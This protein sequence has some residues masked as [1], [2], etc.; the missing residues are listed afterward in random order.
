MCSNPDIKLEGI[1]IDINNIKPFTMVKSGIKDYSY[2]GMR[3]FD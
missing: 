2:L 3:D 1:F